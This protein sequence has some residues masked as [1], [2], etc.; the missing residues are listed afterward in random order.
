MEEVHK[1][2]T[3]GEFVRKARVERELTLR[4]L[5]EKIGASAMT[6]SDIE[7][8]KEYP[9]GGRVLKSLA[10]FFNIDEMVLINL[11]DKTRLAMENKNSK[12]Q[13]ELKLALARKII[14]SDNIDDSVLKKILKLIDGEK[15]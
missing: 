6:I 2:E 3:L 4:Q 5:G 8:N 12:P 11:S 13:Q 14:D 7:N 10:G 9:K 15:N 1:V